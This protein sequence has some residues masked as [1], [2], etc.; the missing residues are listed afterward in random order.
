MRM[1]S[2]R[3]NSGRHHPERSPLIT[4]ER[5]GYDRAIDAPWYPGS[6]VCGTAHLSEEDP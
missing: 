6:C 4:T 2:T 3:A 1:N 5:H